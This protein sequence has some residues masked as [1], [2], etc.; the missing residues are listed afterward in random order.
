MGES[1]SESESTRGGNTDT[2][3]TAIVKI[4]KDTVTIG[5]ATMMITV[6]ERSAAD[7]DD[8]AF[9][10]SRD[11]PPH[12]VALGDHPHPFGGDAPIHRMTI[13][14]IVPGRPTATV[15]RME[16]GRCK[17]GMIQELPVLDHLLLQDEKPRQMETIVL[18]V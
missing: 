15:I 18:H 14:G 4:V 7:T 11:L 3:T 13:A 1:E 6:T 9:L 17:A 12:P 16:F 8:H 5:L 2:I 10:A